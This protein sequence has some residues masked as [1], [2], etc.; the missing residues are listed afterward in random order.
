MFRV[1]QKF[2]NNVKEDLATL[3]R[4]PVPTEERQLEVLERIER[5]INDWGQRLAR[6]QPTEN[7]NQ[8]PDGC[9]AG[10]VLSTPV[11]CGDR[12]NRPDCV[13]PN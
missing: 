4:A 8:S 13:P 7:W 12:Q 2:F 9:F 10:V 1:V 6:M 5:Q 3:G 11:V